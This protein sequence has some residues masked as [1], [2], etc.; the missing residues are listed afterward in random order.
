MVPD[1]G[2]KLFLVNP[3]ILSNEV[4]DEGFEEVFE[5]GIGALHQSVIAQV[6]V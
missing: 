2:L 1:L 3:G 4:V 6:L 5:M